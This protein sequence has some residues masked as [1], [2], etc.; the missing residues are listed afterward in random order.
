[1]S[2][3]PPALILKS[4]LVCP[5]TVLLGLYDDDNKHLVFN[6]NGSWFLQWRRSVF[7]EV[8][9]EVLCYF[10]YRCKRDRTKAEAVSCWPL[11]WR[12]EFDHRS[13]Y[14][15]FM[16][17]KVVL[18]QVFSP[19]M[20]VFPCHYHSTNASYLSSSTYCSYQKDAEVKHG[21]LPKSTFSLFVCVRVR[22]KDWKTRNSIPV[23]FQTR[24]ILLIGNYVLRYFLN[25]CAY[26][27]FCL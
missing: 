2:Y 18:G 16:G 10:H 9:M 5:Q 4:P 7:C 22:R 25:G 21:N 23:N 19:S 14:V 1:L 3:I 12:P 13:V 11:L 15:R 24:L 8:R 20:S 6:Q 17:G 26:K 27:S